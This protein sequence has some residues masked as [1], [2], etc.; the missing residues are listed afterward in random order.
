MRFW[1]WRPPAVVGRR[2]TRTRGV[3]RRAKRVGWRKR[4]RAGGVAGASYGPG[5]SAASGPRHRGGRSSSSRSFTH[6]AASLPS[7]SV[8]Y[9]SGGMPTSSSGCRPGDTTVRLSCRASRPSTTSSRSRLAASAD[10]GKV[11]DPVQ[12]R[13]E[14]QR[15]DAGR[16]RGGDRTGDRRG[17]DPAGHDRSQPEHRIFSDPAVTGGA[18][19]VPDRRAGARSDGQHPERQADHDQRRVRLRQHLS[20]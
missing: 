15:L 1:L 11:L 3:G 18:E 8:R 6:P 14:G 16:W 12:P 17:A 9:G 19:P 20:D 7:T 2:V 13:S 5:V 10:V 4:A